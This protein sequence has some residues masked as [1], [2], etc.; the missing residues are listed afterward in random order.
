MRGDPLRL[1]QVLVNLLSNAVKFTDHGEV[2]LQA[3]CS[4]GDDPKLLLT[5]RD[6]G[7][8]IP[9]EQHASIFGAFTQ[10]DSSSTRRHGGAGLGLA[11]VRDIV[12]LMGGTVA[13]ESLPGQGSIFSVELP[14]EAAEPEGQAPDLPSER[15]AAAIRVLVAE[16]DAVNQLV[17]AGMLERMGCAVETVGDGAA[18]LQACSQGAHDIVF[19]DCHMPVMDGWEAARQIRAAERETGRRRIA[20]VA[21]TAD[22]LPSERERCF[23]AGMD[24]FLT[25]P[26][27]SAQLADAIADWT[28]RVTSNPATQW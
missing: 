15:P 1:R 12:G 20:I 24:D 23:A 16:D 19:M 14:L 2:V 4:N 22:A 9:S 26:V 5:V 8:G 28:G 11:I 21:L 25:K 10:I 17:V 27:S 7:I 3:S 13:V 18:A 6:T